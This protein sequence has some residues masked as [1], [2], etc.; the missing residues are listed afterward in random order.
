MTSVRRKE[1]RRKG[2]DA[3]TTMTYHSIIRFIEKHQGKEQETESRSV[4]RLLT[5][6]II[7]HT[8]VKSQTLENRSAVCQVEIQPTEVLLLYEVN[9]VMVG[10]IQLVV[11]VGLRSDLEE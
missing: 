7:I 1:N 4:R 8:R 6:E 11:D 3:S 9:W 5:A 10:G 2:S